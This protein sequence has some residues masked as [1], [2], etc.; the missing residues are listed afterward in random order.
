V[1]KKKPGPEP[2]VN[3][4]DAAEYAMRFLAGGGR[5]YLL[6]NELEKEFDHRI[7]R[8]SYSRILTRARD[9]LVEEDG[10]T[11]KELRTASRRF[12]EAIRS[13]RA[14]PPAVRVR[15]QEA[16]DKLYGLPITRVIHS[17][18]GEGGAIKTESNTTVEVLAKHVQKFDF[19]ALRNAIASAGAEESGGGGENATNN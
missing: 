3:T 14:I 9:L 15:A 13:D 4:E 18:T 8:K 10:K 11:R 7:S 6:H 19:N 1:K 17:G 5:K 16:I 12:Y 2:T